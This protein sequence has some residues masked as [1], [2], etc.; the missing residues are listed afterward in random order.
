MSPCRG[1][2][3]P[4]RSPGSGPR[5]MRQAEAP[6]RAWQLGHATE[7]P[8]LLAPEG[9]GCRVLGVLW[10]LA[11]REGALAGGHQDL[12]SLALGN[13]TSTAASVMANGGDPEQCYIQTQTLGLNKVGRSA[14]REKG[15]LHLYLEAAK[16][17]GLITILWK[18]KCVMC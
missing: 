17:K 10:G 18:W 12:L 13:L 7:R 4:P 14:R 11:G 6:A 2:L 1:A 16:D 9:A 8:Q 15:Y 5:G 3:K